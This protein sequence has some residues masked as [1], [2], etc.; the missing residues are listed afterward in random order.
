MS[1]PNSTS[2]PIPPVPPAPSFT[3]GSPEQPAAPAAPPAPA[4][5]LAPPAYGE[6]VPGYEQPAAPP[7]APG[8]A[9]PGAPT[10]G[11]PAY[12]T[13][14]YGAPAYGAPGYGAPPA[15]RRRTW[16]VVL[17]VILFVA[18]LIGMIIGLFYAWIFSDPAL[19]AD[20]MSQQGMP[21][22]VDTRGAGLI[23]GVSHPV[24]YLIALGVGILLLV[25]NKIAFWVP[26][27]AGVLA[28]LI[29]WG[30]IFAV[31]LSDPAFMNSVR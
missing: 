8:Y 10:Y 17:T 2:D 18:G 9:Q 3:Y 7:P 29:F 16:D 23:I 28:T 4:E 14:G 21:L 5:P 11:A 19:F 31:V 20:A 26:L 15:P 13:P 25:K 30:T 24:L 1:E 22:T 27:A 12:G 6:R